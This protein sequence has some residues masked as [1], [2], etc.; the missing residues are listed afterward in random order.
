MKTSIKIT[1]KLLLLCLFLL[2]T[3]FVHGLKQS[4]EAS[5]DWLQSLVYRQRT[6]TQNMHLK[7]S[8][9]IL[10][11]NT[12]IT[13]P[14]EE[15]SVETTK[16]HPSVVPNTAVPSTKQQKKIYIYNTHQSEAYQDGKTVLDAALILGKKLEEKGYKVVVETNDFIAYMRSQG[17]DYN[18]SYKVSYKYLNDALVNYGGFDLVID[19]HRDSVPR[20]ASVLTYNNK[21][22]AKTMMVVGGLG[23]NAQSAT[24]VSTTL[25]DII[26]TK[27]NGM[28]KSVMIREAYYNQEVHENIV[29]ME[30]GSDANTF[31][32]VQ[33]SI[34]V[35]VEGIDELLK[36]EHQ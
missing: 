9:N 33:N 16:E 23:K 29:L 26:N 18:S 1:A 20:S 6:Y 27:V 24:A 31:S 7:E 11:Y 3:P 14:K 34:D 10:S 32:E 17:W 12:N 25:T 15:I 13:L 35:L 22:Y 2:F 8:L 30:V 5:S 36:G 21:N 4:L 28:M 19:F